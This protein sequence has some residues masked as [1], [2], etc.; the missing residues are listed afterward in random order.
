[1]LSHLTKRVANKH[2]HVHIFTENP[3]K[4]IRSLLEFMTQRGG[5]GVGEEGTHASYS[6]LTAEFR[7]DANFWIFGKSWDDGRIWGEE[8]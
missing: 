6:C 7:P 4:Q 8:S 5:G 2:N 1:M 3:P